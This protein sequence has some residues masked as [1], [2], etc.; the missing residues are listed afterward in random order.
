[1]S[2]R[3]INDKSVKENDV[4]VN[5]T[6]N[7]QTKQILFKTIPIKIYGKNK[8]V[9]AFAFIGEV[10]SVSLV[11]ESLVNELNLSGVSTPWCLRWTGGVERNEKDSKK[12]TICILG[13]NKQTVVI[14]AF[15]VKSLNL[16][17][18]TLVYN[19]MSQRYKHLQHLP[20]D[21]YT[22]AVP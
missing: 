5:N 20:V 21:S 18:Q 17:T 16:P 3:G 14:S 22:N 6:H 10:S 15:T 7:V 9:N 2:K 1:M 8:T 12:V 4:I 19:T 13:G 11:D